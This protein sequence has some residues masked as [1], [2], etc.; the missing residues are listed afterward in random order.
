MLAVSRCT[1]VFGP[2]LAIAGFS[3][4]GFAAVGLA[5]AGLAATAGLLA[6]AAPAASASF[7][8][9]AM[10]RISDT[11]G[12]APA[13]GLAAAG[14][15]A[16][17]FAAGFSAAGSESGASAAGACG[18]AASA[19]LPSAARAAARISATDNFFFSAIESP[20]GLE[21]SRR[22]TTARLSPP[23]QNVS[24]AYGFGVFDRENWG[25]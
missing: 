3:A 10:A 11:L 21:R 20:A 8:A 15:A 14:L 7:F 18:S 19:P 2:P 22:R 13:A 16:A 12:R 17:G 1:P 24:P 9:R 6:G 5:A 23:R 25:S 4:A